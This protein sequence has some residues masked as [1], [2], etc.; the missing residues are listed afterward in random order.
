MLLLVVCDSKS[1]D[2]STPW[3]FNAKSVVSLSM[4]GLMTQLP[5]QPEQNRCCAHTPE[6]W[7]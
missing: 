5:H 4:Q 7:M 6:A 2:K 3:T 1:P